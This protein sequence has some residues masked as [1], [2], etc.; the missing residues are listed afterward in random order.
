MESAGR[1][2]DAWNSDNVSSVLDTAEADY[3]EKV[4]AGIF[5]LLYAAPVSVGIVDFNRFYET[6]RSSLGL[7]FAAAKGNS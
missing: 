2:C 5:R 6:I 4:T 1:R 7:T 3:L